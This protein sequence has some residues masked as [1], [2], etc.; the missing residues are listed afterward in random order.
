MLQVMEHNVYSNILHHLQ[1]HNILCEE[2]HGFRSGRSCETQ[3]LN[4][5]NDFA[6]NLDDKRQTDIILLDFSKTFDKIPHHRLCLKLSHYGIH[7]GTLFWIESF[8]TGR[9]Q[10]VIVNGCSDNPTNVMSG[11]PQ[12]TVL[13]PL[14]LFF[15]YIN[16]LPENVSSK[17]RLY[18]DDVLLYNTIHTKEDCLTLQ[19][20]L[21]T[22]QLWATNDSELT[23]GK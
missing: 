22:L 18:A 4:T 10:Q 3:L 1:R 7:G 14:L 6:K 19:E 2:R 12:G 11:V 5:I 20:N 16:D 9:S 8:L 17:V 21:N 13:T 15:C 23:N